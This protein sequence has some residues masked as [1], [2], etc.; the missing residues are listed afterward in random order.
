MEEL[1]SSKIG[2][3]V[4]EK[5]WM[6]EEQIGYKQSLI[7]DLK[8]WWLGMTVVKIRQDRE[9]GRVFTLCGTKL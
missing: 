5:A 9:N 3:R 2:T 1:S 4:E 7:C 8:M 6:G